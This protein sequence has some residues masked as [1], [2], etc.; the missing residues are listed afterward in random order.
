MLPSSRCHS[1]PV[2]CEARSSCSTF[3]GGNLLTFVF[4]RLSWSPLPATSSVCYGCPPLRSR[5]L[6]HWLLFGLPCT[7]ARKLSLQSCV[8]KFTRGTTVLGFG[9]GETS[10]SRIDVTIRT[11]FPYMCFE[12]FCFLQCCQ[13]LSAWCEFSV[14]PLEFSVLGFGW[15]TSWIRLRAVTC[16]VSCRTLLQIGPA[17]APRRTYGLPFLEAMI[18]RRCLSRSGALPVLP[19]SVPLAHHSPDTLPVAVLGNAILSRVS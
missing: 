5:P 1:L 2:R 16:G 3:L 7:R 14:A 10:H 18:S 15:R 11:L 4:I 8:Q 19:T 17:S 12:H 9:F 13:A 6:R